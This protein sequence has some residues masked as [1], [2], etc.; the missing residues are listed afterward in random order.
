MNVFSR[1]RLKW[2]QFKVWRSGHREIE[3]LNQYIDALKAE[4]SLL[5]ALRRTDRYMRP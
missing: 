2:L 4:N 3:R 1:L 5:R